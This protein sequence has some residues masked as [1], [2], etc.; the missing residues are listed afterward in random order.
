[1]LTDPKMPPPRKGDDAFEWKGT[2]DLTGEDRFE[3]ELPDVMRAVVD[4]FRGPSP[5]LVQRAIE[6][7]RRQRRANVMRWSGALAVV[8]CVGSLLVSTASGGPRFFGSGEDSAPAAIRPVDLRKTWNGDLLDDLA[9][10]LPPGGTVSN[11]E[12]SFAGSGPLVLRTEAFVAAQFANALGTSRIEV[13]VSRMGAGPA[14]AGLPHCSTAVFKPQ[15]SNSLFYDGS[16]ET[17]FEDSGPPKSWAA[18]RVWPDNTRVVARVFAPVAGDGTGDP[19]LT[20]A[21]IAGVADNPVWGDIRSALSPP[22]TQLP[23]LLTDVVASVIPGGTVELLG[24]GP[25]TADAVIRTGKS[26]VRVRIHLKPVAEDALPEC[27]RGDCQITA[28]DDMPAKSETYYVEDGVSVQQA[29]TVIHPDGLQVA[30][31]TGVVVL[32]DQDTKAY[33]SGL[34]TKQLQ[35]IATSPLW[36]A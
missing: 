30:V 9:A 31:E 12:A 36:D 35:K 5:D 20:M 2:D 13:T 21:E 29:L 14:A 32:K 27:A 19:V 26:A 8:L 11:G 17:K 6:R 1:M 10:A 34:T 18:M 28:L 3:R 24:A 25:T 23:Q 4:E 16:S 15:C 33:G 22:E 7:G